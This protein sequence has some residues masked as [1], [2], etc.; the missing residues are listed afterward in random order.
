MKLPSLHRA[1]LKVV[2]SSKRYNVVDCGRRWGKTWL[3][4]DRNIRGALEHAPVAW[5]SPTYKDLADIWRE[6]VVRIGDAASRTDASENRIELWGGGSI[7]FWSLDNPDSG[8]GR[9]YR[10]VVVDEAAK[11]AKLEQAWTQTI[12]PTLTDFKGDAWFL[13]TPRGID[14]F[15]K[16]YQRGLDPQYG[17]WACWRL[18]TVSNPYIDPQEVEDA[19][20]DLPERA[21]AQEYQAEFL[22][23]GGAVF[24]YV[25]AA[26]TE[27]VLRDRAEPYHSYAIGWDPAKAD[28]F[29]VLTVVD[30]ATRSVV[31]F[32]RFNQLDYLFQIDRLRALCER[33]QPQMVVLEETGNLALADIV[34]RATYRDPDGRAQSIPLW[35]FS[36]TN[37][38]KA[39]I[40]QALALAFE[41]H[42]IHLPD[43]P[44]LLNE[45]R[46]FTTERLPSGA[47]RYAAPEGMHDDCLKAGTL[48]K[49]Y[50]GYK[51]IESIVAGDL[52]LTHTNR[53]Q[54][55][56]AC[57]AKPFDGVFHKFKFRG[58]LELELS[59]NHPLYAAAR[60]YE[61][62]QSGPFTRRQ[63]VVPDDWKKTYRAVSIVEQLQKRSPA[64]LTE[65]VFY[66]P[67]ALDRVKFRGWTLDTNAAR[68]LGRFLADGHAIQ[69]RA[70][71]SYKLELAFHIDD[72]AK[73]WFQGY[74]EGL[75]VAARFEPI[76][77][78]CLKLVFA[79]KLLWHALSLCYTDQREKCVPGWLGLFGTAQQAVL[80]E[81]LAGDGWIREEL[82][83]HI[84]ATASKALALNMRDIAWSVGRY[85]TILK[86][87]RHRY[88]KPCKD[89]YWVTIQEARPEHAHMRLLS[90]FEYGGTVRSHSTEH[91]QGTVYNLQVA[92]DR[93]FV[94]NGLVVHNCVLSLALAWAHTKLTSP[95]ERLPAAER[96]RRK[97]YELIAADSPLATADVSRNYHQAAFLR[98]EQRAERR[99]YGLGALEA[100]DEEGQG[101]PGWAVANGEDW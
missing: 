100:D 17:D 46:A 72:P 10:R 91:F 58:N 64:T 25:D 55:V 97:A 99:S 71:S 26:I 95:G 74:L 49:T 52:V 81:W 8:R 73:D 101:H 28:D 47:I 82:N 4:L 21:Y 41:R 92:E 11:V 89:Q 63:W 7:D 65:S 80:D 60:S 62:D 87:H 30:L 5:F 16:L 83:Q 84:G 20:Q 79:S 22:E 69:R 32:D 18:P 93:S 44:V 39:E 77:D 70:G 68:L 54:L 98:E 2:A 78:R 35:A 51:P 12:R 50:Q 88:G 31:Y 56:E 75:G 1:Q 59:Y 27:G 85:A 67:N 29:T 13:S 37:A 15:W 34:R 23:D 43:N 6:F 3:G 53:Y 76:G 14:Y 42:D 45:L 90:E 86:N 33:F 66:E 38:S 19:R 48:I 96:A 24:R 40:I 9:K 61:G 36:T 57:I 94:A